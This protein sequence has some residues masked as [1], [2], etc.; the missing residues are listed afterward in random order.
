[1]PKNSSVEKDRMIAGQKCSDKDVNSKQD[2]KAIELKSSKDAFTPKRIDSKIE[3][4]VL[5]KGPGTDASPTRKDV[6]TEINALRKN[7]GT[8]ALLRRKDSRTETNAL[9]KT[10]S[11]DATLRRKDS[12]T[13]INALQKGLE[14][15]AIPSRK[16]SVTETS[17]WRKNPGTDALLRRK[18]S[19]TETNA[20]R[21]T[22]STDATQRRKDSGTEIN[23][24]QKGIESD[25]IPSRKDSGTEAKAL[26]KG[27]GTDA[28]PRRKDSGTEDHPRKKSSGTEIISVSG[29]SGLEGHVKRED[30]RT[31]HA[32][33]GRKDSVTEAS[34]PAPNCSRSNI[35]N[36]SPRTKMQTKL[37]AL[38]RGWAAY[39]S[40]TS[41]HGTERQGSPE[42]PVHGES[43]RG[44]ARCS[45]FGGVS[46]EPGWLKVGLPRIYRLED[47][48]KKCCLGETS[49]SL[50]NN[51]ALPLNRA[52]SERRRGGKRQDWAGLSH[53]RSRSLSGSLAARPLPLLG[54]TG[55]A[56]SR[57]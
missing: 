22:P 34:P 18:D 44:A 36:H 16:D 32:G 47:L 23:A 41:Q 10:P 12:G 7:P 9:R 40:L 24:L 20:L 8:D 4:S 28:S 49:G 5:K 30:S 13:E 27:L 17:A 33:H 37:R 35:L 45:G 6:G 11:T 31:R 57:L 50:E 1:M 48:H 15:D 14:S 42:Q 51:G 26:R 55:A 39:R 25:A 3:L 52:R 21:K 53:V 38:V 19:G 29:S 56:G 46:P 2:R 54:K 43:S